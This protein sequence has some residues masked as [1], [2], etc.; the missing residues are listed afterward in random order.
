MPP[1]L[2]DDADAW[3]DRLQTK[4]ND[5]DEFAEAAAGFDATFRFHIR[6]DD[7]YDGDPLAF[8]VVVTDG[9]CVAARGSDSDTEYD[10]A[11]SGPYL[12]WKGLLQGETDV[13]SAVMGGEF[14]LQGST[15]EL[16]NH[17]EA[18]AELVRAAQSIDTEFAY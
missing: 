13:T 7:A 1:T 2:P 17:R 16:M 15:M 5:S 10:F 18:V 12:D 9:A 4:V 3:A 8:T 14:D 11:L 6:P